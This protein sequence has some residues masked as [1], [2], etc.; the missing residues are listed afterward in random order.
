MPRSTLARRPFVVSAVAV[1]LQP[2]KGG[3]SIC[4][5][6]PDAPFPEMQ[7][8]APIWAAVRIATE[9][10]LAVPEGAEPE[11]APAVAD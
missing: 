7:D 10:S 2:L 11:D 4:R 5:L 9:L 8:S 6:D 3:V 1:E